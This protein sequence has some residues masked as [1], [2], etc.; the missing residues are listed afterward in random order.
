MPEAIKY[1]TTT[2]PARRPSGEI[3]ALLAEYGARHVSLE[4]DSEGEPA[5]VS[6]ASHDPKLGQLVAA[7]APTPVPARDREAC[8]Q[9]AE[10]QRRALLEEASKAPAAVHLG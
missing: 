6:F 1:E 3:M 9:R 2:I 7:E 4:Y 10:E 5:T 8:R